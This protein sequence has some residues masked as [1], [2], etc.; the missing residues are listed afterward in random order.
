MIMASE[1]YVTYIKQSWCPYLHNCEWADIF[2]PAEKRWLSFINK[3][4]NVLLV[5][6]ASHLN[7]LQYNT[8]FSFTFSTLIYIDVVLP[9][10]SNMLLL[11]HEPIDYTRRLIEAS[12]QFY[13]TCPQL[14]SMLT[15]ILRKSKCFIWNY[16]TSYSLQSRH[17]YFLGRAVLKSDKCH[18]FL[19]TVHS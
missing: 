12:L 6:I 1:A 18:P 7:A 9:L 4:N 11:P 16:S 5:L 17:Q 15:E 2:L 3:G 19:S 14:S 10:H 13:E 8:L